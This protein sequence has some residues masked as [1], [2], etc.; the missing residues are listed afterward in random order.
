MLGAERR[1]LI[2]QELTTAGSV[3]VSALATSLQVDPVTVRRD[4]ARLE[5]AGHLQRV[6]GG[7]ILRESIGDSSPPSGLARR[8]A[9]AAA[10]LISTGSV[11]FL[12][13]GTFTP[14]IILSL[15]REKQLTIITNALDV[16]WRAARTQ[17]HTLHL[18]GGEVGRDYGIYGQLEQ[19]FHLLVDWVIIEA[20]GLSAESGLTHDHLRYAN[21]ARTLLKQSAKTMVLLPPERVGQVGAL[22][23][24][25]VEQID[26]LITGREASNAPLW[27]LSEA[28]VRIVL[29]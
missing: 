10:R 7:A 12:G 4:L 14:E 3:Q 27:D 11:V 22:H 26:L 15:G 18:L 5:S 8:I 24:A 1:T 25:P 23:S 28:G 13:P 16:A 2:L 21:L 29:T 9:E 6:H 20:A 17:Q 19:Q